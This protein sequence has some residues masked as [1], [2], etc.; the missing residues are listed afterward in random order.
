MMRYPM[1]KTKKEITI[2]YD[3]NDPIAVHIIPS[4]Y[5]DYFIILTEDLVDIQT[6]FM[7]RQEVIERFGEEVLN[8]HVV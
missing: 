8:S 4:G 7:S 2:L 6:H 3:H 5:H 1:Y